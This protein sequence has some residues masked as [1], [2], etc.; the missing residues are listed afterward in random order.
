MNFAVIKNAVI[1][2]VHC[3]HFH[4]KLCASLSLLPFSVRSTLIGMNLRP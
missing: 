1:K 4:G 3:I 2:R